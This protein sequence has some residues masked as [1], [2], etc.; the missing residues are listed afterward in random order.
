MMS[1]LTEKMIKLE[2]CMKYPGEDLSEIDRE[3]NV[4]SEQLRALELKQERDVV[5]ARGVDL[6]GR[7][8]QNKLVNLGVEFQALRSKFNHFIN[9][10][11]LPLQSAIFTH[12]PGCKCMGYF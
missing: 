12:L 4:L 1:S 2:L 8:M 10:H 11:F 3:Y 5:E 7:W 9:K 6:A